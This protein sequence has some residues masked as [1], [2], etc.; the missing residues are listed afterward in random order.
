MTA[1]QQRTFTG[2]LAT[3]QGTNPDLYAAAQLRGYDRTL[4]PGYATDEGVGLLYLGTTF[5][6][7]FAENSDGG[8]YF[9]EP[10]GEHRLDVTRL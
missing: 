5:A 1:G 7:A 6:G 4:P 2:F 8:A 3:A 9:V 10:G